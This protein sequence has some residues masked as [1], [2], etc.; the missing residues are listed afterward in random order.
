[1]DDPHARRQLA[2][3][4]LLTILFF[5][6]LIGEAMA[7]RIARFWLS[8]IVLFGVA[9]V[10]L[11]WALVGV[12]HA[13]DAIHPELTP[14]FKTLKS[15]KGMCCDG[16]DALHLSDVDWETQNKETSHYRVRIPMN[17]ADM[18]KAA[19]GEAVETQW[20]DVPDDAVVT[21]PNRDGVTLVW[22]IYGYLGASVR[23]FLPG[24]MG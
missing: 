21:E 7:D 3:G 19:M 1:M 2:A 16:Y 20:V 13:H 23:C 15:G 5:I 14:W 24:S 22:P 18:A 6:M 10:F 12:A 11:I 4:I 9:L 8:A 17:S